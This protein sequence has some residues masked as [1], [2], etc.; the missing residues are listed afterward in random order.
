MMS[1]K[2]LLTTD[3]WEKW[4]WLWQVIFYGGVLITTLLLINNVQQSDT[5]LLAGT[6]TAI[7]LL[8]HTIGF[9]FAYRSIQDVDQWDKRALTR[10]LIILGDI[11]LWFLLVNISPVYYIILFGLFV[12]VFRH[13]PVGFSAIASVLLTLA[14]LM[15]Q[16]LDSS[17]GFS[18]A[19][20]VFWLYILMGAASVAVGVWV[21][22]IINQ[23]MQRRELIEQLDAT[24]KELAAAER[25][26]GVLEERQRLAREIHDTLA[27]GF[28]SIV[29]HLEA[30]EQA[31]EQ[32]IPLGRK[33]LDS[34][35]TTARLSLEQARRVVQDLR[36][37]LLETYG[38]TRA[39]ERTV[40]R[41]QQETGITA[42]A[43]ITGQP[44]PLLSEMEVT[45]LRATGE[46]LSNIRK[47]ARAT[48]V[49]VTLSYMGDVV[50]LDVHDNGIGLNSPSAS[51]FVGGYG[52]EA[53][54]ERI[55]QC[56]GALNL[57]S[58]P[59]EGT[60]LVVTIPLSGQSKDSDSRSEQG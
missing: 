17:E 13:L 42:R 43:H 54:R 53:M 26:E 19:S 38:L 36:P 33:H 47:H 39:I 27:Q 10:F 20:P 29:M 34:A 11:S 35:R 55:Q 37:E 9:Y 46:A 18:L 24:R 56:G 30:A 58:D 7:L 22:S 23:S 15:E 59:G 12:Q 57:E 51:P 40:T 52:L 6:L 25:R 4:E 21:S 1:N 50:M 28:T 8:W 3:I 2:Q 32:D 31:I 49:Q 44:V 16:I 48:E 45:L 14:S 41:W 60:T 5:L